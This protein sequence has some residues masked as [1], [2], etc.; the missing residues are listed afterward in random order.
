MDESHRY[1]ASAGVRAINELLPIL[2]LELTATPFVETSKAA[3]PFKNII[4]D[5]PLGL[6]M[7]DGFVK[8]PA[9]VTRKNFLYTI[10]P[11]R[12]ANARV[13]IEQSIGRGLRLPYGKRTGV[14]AVDRLSIVAH[15]RFQEIVDEAARPG[16]PIRMQS[17]IL[18]P[19]E[20]E[21]R[22]KT[23]VLQS[24]V[25]NALGIRPPHA[26][27][28]TEVAG[29]D[30]PRA[31]ESPAEQEIARLAYERIRA[32]SARPNLA[33]SA[34]ALSHPDLQAQI[35]REV[36]EI[37][38]PE[39]FSIAE[40]E[41]PPDVARIVAKTTDIVIRGSIDVPRVQVVPRGDVRASFQPF[42]LDLSGLRYPPRRR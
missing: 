36:A 34:G 17:V 21:K 28:T 27:A 16:S 29:A 19:S 26:S 18:D 4:L 30:S 24:Q 15:D 5:Y 9:V 23:V 39:Q 22:T 25:A 10:V 42:Q 7:A 31:F 1:R 14:T 32:L 40:V 37:Y 38:R 20:L 2:G 8:E 13:L 3:V 35:S 11:L 33:P 41:E 6:A 12:A